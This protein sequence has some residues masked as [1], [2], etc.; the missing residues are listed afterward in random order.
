MRLREGVTLDASLE[1]RIREAIRRNAS[2][3]HVPAVI[4]AVPDMPRTL[5]GKLVELAVREVVHG[6][7]VKNL[8][9]LANPQ[10][11]EHFR[12]RRELQQEERPG[13][14]SRHLRSGRR[15]LASS[16]AYARS[17]RHLECSPTPALP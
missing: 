10:A 12:D 14:L 15:S 1:Q 4:L 8:D 5:S 7:P 13:Q 6:R 17:P 2:P 16:A 9:A 11:L 3:R